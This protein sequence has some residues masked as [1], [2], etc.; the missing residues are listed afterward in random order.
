M[1]HQFLTKNLTSLPPEVTAMVLKNLP[2]FNSLFSAIQTCQQLYMCYR[3]DEN[4]TITS[5]FSTVLQNAIC[6]DRQYGLLGPALIIQE[7]I[8][9][10]KRACVNGDSILQIFENT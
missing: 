2:D 6:Y 8:N 10:I 3:D 1:K 4:S 7:L 9:A 5:I